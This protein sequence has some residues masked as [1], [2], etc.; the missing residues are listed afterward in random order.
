[1]IRFRPG[2]DVYDLSKQLY[3]VFGKGSF[4]SRTAKEHGIPLNHARINRMKSEKALI[5][6]GKTN[7]PSSVGIYKLNERHIRYLVADE[8][9]EKELKA[10]QDGGSE[11]ELRCYHTE[12]SKEEMMEQEMD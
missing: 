11:M 4:T 6:V 10:M 5:L 2:T 3:A 9:V 12:E 8:M 7:P 1:M